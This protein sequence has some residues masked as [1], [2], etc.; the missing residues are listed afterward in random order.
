MRIILKSLTFVYR[1]I[2]QNKKNKFYFVGFFLIIQSFLEIIGLGAIIPLLSVILDENILENRYW[3]N[4]IYQT[5]NLSSINSLIIVFAIFLFCIILF[6]NCI[7][8][9]IS[10]YNIRFSL[11]LYKDFAL[12]MHKHYYNKGVSFF[13]SNNSTSLI[14][15][16]NTASFHGST[17]I[18]LG[19]LNLINELLILFVLVILINLYN[20]KVFLIL[21]FIVMPPFLFSYNLIR[22]RSIKI[23]RVLKNIEPEIHK[24]YFQSVLGYVDIIITGTENIF[25]KKI[26][27][28]LEKRV[29]TFTDS[30]LNNLIPSKVLETALMF[31]LSVVVVFSTYNL[32]SNKEIISLI[33]LLAIAGYRILPS[34]NRLSSEFLNIK[35]RMPYGI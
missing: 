28:D 12:K 30:F 26:E 27:N 29:T 2:P 7:A 6:K 33:G 1:I 10:K 21:F 19:I 32:Y 17:D 13:Q 11:S 22:I 14:R 34:I 4:W 8:I 35:F 23:G 24:N 25:R 18:V 20:Y 3:A 5:L 9:F 31:T 16:I 15:D